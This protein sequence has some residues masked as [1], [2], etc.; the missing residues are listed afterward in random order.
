[1]VED[2]W[3]RPVHERRMAAVELL[4]LNA[5]RLRYEDAAL[6]ER[7]L[8]ESRTWALVDGLA[9]SVAGRLVE[10]DERFGPVLDRWA[11]D[12]DFWIRRSSLLALLV[13]CAGAPATSSASAATPTPCSTSAS[14]SFARPSAG[15]CG[16]RR[17]RAP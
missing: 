11:T 1:M 5:D 3:A 4:A 2:L 7:L 13:P 6:L 8:R 9:T 14:S 15:C 12:D 16:T 17:G 10:G